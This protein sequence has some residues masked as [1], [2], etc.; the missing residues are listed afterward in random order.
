M[1]MNEDRQGARYPLARAGTPIDHCRATSR[2]VP[3]PAH[4]S[5]RVTSRRD[6]LLNG[7]ILR[8]S[9]ALSTSAVA[10]AAGGAVFW[11]I[12]AQVTSTANVGRVAGLSSVV[13]LVLHVGAVGLIPA[14]A[15]FGTAAD[16][17][18]RVVH[19]LALLF[20]MLVS[21]VGA[22]IVVGVGHA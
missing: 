10:T 12:A 18:S 6:S 20:A 13:S 8:G 1:R 15:R 11:V 3:V 5:A 4:V 17:A 22:T 14:V 21:I 19:N 9:F 16:R 2:V 7:S